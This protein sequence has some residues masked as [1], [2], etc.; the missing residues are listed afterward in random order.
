MD[1]L[2]QLFENAQLPTDFAAKAS[3]LFEASINEAVEARVKAE[4]KRIQEAAEENLE[5]AKKDWIAEADEDLDKFLDVQVKEW[6]QKNAAAL[7]G[8]TKAKLAE[9]IMSKLKGLLEAEGIDMPAEKDKA[10]TEADEDIKELEEEVEDL[11]K[12]LEEAKLRIVSFT[13][14]QIVREATKSLTKVAASR[15]SSLA[16]NISFKNPRQYAGAVATLTE[17]F[18]GKKLKL[19][20]GVSDKFPATED[21]SDASGKDKNK[22]AAE[23]NEDATAANKFPATT[24]NSDSAGADKNKA[25]VNEAEDDD[26]YFE[27]DLKESDDQKADK[28]SDGVPEDNEKPKNAETVTEAFDIVALTMKSLRG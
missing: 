9:D 16:E 20:E 21:N 15:V 24:D 1:K 25:A 4:V 13:K 6:A 17:A 8:T 26:E 7:V 19:K 2:K 12:E 27:D 5:K 14:R 10:I 23:V 11:K 28:D 18:G 22:A 3:V